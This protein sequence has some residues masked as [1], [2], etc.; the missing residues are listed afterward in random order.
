MYM[1]T[2]MHIRTYIRVYVQ[3]ICLLTHSLS[4][5]VG[6]SHIFPSHL[7]GLMPQ[8]TIPWLCHIV[9]V[10]LCIYTCIYH[11]IHTCIY[12]CIYPCIHHLYAYTYILHTRIYVFM[13]VHIL[14][15]SI[16]VSR[17]KE[18]EHNSRGV[19]SCPARVCIN[20]YTANC[21]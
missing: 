5:Y 10:P 11:Y 21:R 12:H 14:M 3:H 8:K 7:C 19:Q 4:S 18:I 1:F 16:A 13:Y 20:V 6:Q 17:C 15:K 9:S 2:Y